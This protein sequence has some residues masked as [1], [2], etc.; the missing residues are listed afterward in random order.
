[1]VPRTPALFTNPSIRPNASHALCTE[2]AMAGS[3]ALTS[4]SIATDRTADG[5]EAPDPLI[6]SQRDLN[7]SV[8]RAAAMTRQPAFARSR[9]RS[10]PMPEDAPVTMTTLPSK[11]LHG[12]SPGVRFAASFTASAMVGYR[13]REGHIYINIAVEPRKGRVRRNSVAISLQITMIA[14]G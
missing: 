7:R 2:A 11:L 8:R 3:S 13:V 9:H 4:S 10:R 14:V 1:M 6:S 5:S 12:M